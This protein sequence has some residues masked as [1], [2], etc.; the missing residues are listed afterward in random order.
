VVYYRSYYKTPR[1]MLD[2]PR[3]SFDKDTE[4]RSCIRSCKCK[5]KT[6]I[7]Q[8]SYR[9]GILSVT[10]SSVLII[11]TDTERQNYE[12]FDASIGEGLSHDAFVGKNT[13]PAANCAEIF[14]TR[15]SLSPSGSMSMT[16]ILSALRSWIR[17]ARTRTPTA[18]C[19]STFR[20]EP[21]SRASLRVI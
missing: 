9:I 3:S 6:A 13:E 11:V 4:I 8:I 20:E 16:A 15:V 14:A 7:L 17:L 5:H 12:I 2:L 21:T 18:C 19:V 10:G 1:H